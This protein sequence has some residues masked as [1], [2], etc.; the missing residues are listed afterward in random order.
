VTVD[1]PWVLA[2]DFGTS[3]CVVAVRVGEGPTEVIEIGGERRVPSVV[4]CT[5]AGDIV[6]GRVA[7]DLMYGDPDRAL[8]APKAHIGEPH[9]VVIAG[10]P[11]DVAILVTE[12]L[13]WLA[14]QAVAQV[15]SP[16]SQV[17]LTHPA[18]WGAPRRDQLRRAAIAA[19]LERPVLVPEP[20]AAAVAYAEVT[21]AEVGAHVAVYDLGGGTYDT[22]VLRVVAPGSFE[23]VGRPTGDGQIGGELFDDLLLDEVTAA[24]APATRDAL[25]TASG[26][27]WMQADARLRSEVRRAKEALSSDEQAEVTV[28]TPTGLEQTH[29]TRARFEELIAPSID[30]SVAIL[31]RSVAAAG[32]APGDLAAI[33]LAGGAS[34]IPLVEARLVAAFPGVPVTRRADPKTSV[35]VG[36]AMLSPGTTV[37]AAES[38]PSHAVATGEVQWSE[39][40][41]GQWAVASGTGDWEPAEAPPGSAWSSLSTASVAES[42]GSLPP[43]S[44]PVG[45]QPSGSLPPVP[46]SPGS[47]PPTEARSAGRASRPVTAESRRTR[48]RRFVVGAVVAAALVG[49]GVTAVVATSSSGHTTAPPVATT[50]PTGVAPTTTPDTALATVS[51]VSEAVLQPQDFADSGS[52]TEIRHAALC[53]KYPR[54][55]TFAITSFR[56]ADGG[57]L[58]SIVGAFSSAAVASEAMAQMPASRSY[59][60]ADANPFTLTTLRSAKLDDASYTGDARAT[61]QTGKPL[62]YF[63]GIVRDGRN[64]GVVQVADPDS[65]TTAPYESILALAAEKLRGVPQ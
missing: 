65:T 12:V 43:V 61:F 7:E 44:E 46:E 4:F 24:L 27:E 56:L 19:G 41:A 11:W 23:I 20:V 51:E 64:L 62:F 17:R 57:R 18:T 5:E 10:R 45:S 60:T 63:L 42:P 39:S 54:P 26:A 48:R 53:G 16:A 13:A 36:A 40:V 55:Q 49:V 29:V 6:V 52:F 21:K 22:T 37:P 59:C 1:A 58:D 15:G 25:L 9:P 14:A 50:T 30:E 33:H 38:G 28:A 8:R 35:A 31:E 2:I 34:R 3:N 47:L 32:L